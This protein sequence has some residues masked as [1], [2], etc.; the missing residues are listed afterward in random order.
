MARTPRDTERLEFR[1]IDASFCAVFTAEL[2][3]RLYAHGRSLYFKSDWKWSVFDTVLVFFQIVDELTMLFL[4]GSNVQDAID[5]MGV[6]RM[7]R[8]LRILRLIRMVRLIPELKSLVC[9]IA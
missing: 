6:L 1:L 2:C 4:T 3:A 9:L 7:L 5:Q 8:L